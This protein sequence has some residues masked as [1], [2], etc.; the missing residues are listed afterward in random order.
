M[1]PPKI[2]SS[3]VELSNLNFKSITSFLETNYSKGERK[4]QEQ[5][6][7]EL[8]LNIHPSREHVG[9]F[10]EDFILTSRYNLKYIRPKTSD[11][12]KIIFACERNSKKCRTD[13]GHVDHNDSEYNSEEISTKKKRSNKKGV[14]KRNEE[15]ACYF[16][17]SFELNLDEQYC[18]SELKQMHNHEPYD[19]VRNDITI[20][21]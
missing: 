2:F 20:S 13:E 1:I 16:R 17:L 6:I 5:A 12:K 7:S 18:F 10:V 8:M 9:R 11:K 4:T 15:K 21:F 19:K 3:K 14:T